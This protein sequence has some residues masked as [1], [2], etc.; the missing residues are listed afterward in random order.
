ME[1]GT[2][3]SPL[4]SPTRSS[5][6]QTPARTFPMPWR[7]FWRRRSRP[8]AEGHKI[9][10]AGAALAFLLAGKATLTVVSVRTGND[11]ASIGVIKD[12]ER[13]D[14]GHRADLPY[15]DKRTRG[16]RYVFLH[17]SEKMMPPKAEIWHEG[18]CGRCARPLTDPQSIARGI[19]PECASKMECF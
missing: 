6:W 7:A 19:G 13:F 11:Y 16:F 18:T 3:S 1:S 10:D 15:D 14:V 4:P 17:L 9:E 5:K 12:K 8:M 2:A